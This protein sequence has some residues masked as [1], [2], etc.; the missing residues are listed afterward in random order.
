MWLPAKDLVVLHDV[1]LGVPEVDPVAAVGLDQIQAALD[2]VAADANIVAALDIDAVQR[3][4]DHV[5]SNRHGIGLDEHAGHVFGQ[6]RT[7]LADV[8]A[9]EHRARGLDVHDVTLVAATYGGSP[10]PGEGDRNLDDQILAI[11]STR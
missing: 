11:L 2:P 8:Q 6:A 3:L 9:L 5:V 10:V 4:G 7:R 1:V